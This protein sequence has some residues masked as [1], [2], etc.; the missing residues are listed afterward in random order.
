LLEER[1]K[2]DGVGMLQFECTV[3]NVLLAVSLLYWPFITAYIV[4]HYQLQLLSRYEVLAS[5]LA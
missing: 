2:A 1:K 4:K 3:S 5:L